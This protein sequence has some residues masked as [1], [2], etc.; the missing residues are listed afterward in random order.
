MQD[1]TRLRQPES[2]SS[3]GLSIV[4]P[5]LNELEVLPLCLHRLVPLLEQEEGIYEIV[6]VDDGSTDGSVAWLREAMRINPAIRIVR[7]SRNF[8]KEAAMTAGLAHARGAAVI[9]LDADLQDPPELIPKM[10]QAWRDGADVVSMRRRSRDGEGWAKRLS[11]HLFYRVL[12]RLSRSDIPADTGDFRL[13]SR[14]AV[15][16]LLSLPERSRYMK[17]LYAWIGM[18]T[19]VIEYDR[20][21]RAAGKT[22]WS[23]FALFG[24][25]MEGITSFSIRP[26]RWA[27]GIG[28]VVAL[29]GGIFGVV[30]V[31]K[32]LILGH[33]APGYP[34]LMAVIT[35]FSGLQ[36][37]TI[38]LLGEY[39]GKVYM[40]TKQRPIFLVRD[41]IEVQGWADTRGAH[42]ELVDAHQR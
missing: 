31:L 18:P 7:L 28:A 33:Q 4:I 41:V 24:L 38:G 22:K 15:D 27:T 40:E 25:A 42:L 36:L 21:P 39:L 14:T 9:V 10:V 20:A 35:L 30:I 8:G 17:G 11:A 34:S 6:F 16:A 1:R 37:L 2:D 3:I 32:T 29:A 26:L 12:R 23:Y 5:F 13:M 19:R